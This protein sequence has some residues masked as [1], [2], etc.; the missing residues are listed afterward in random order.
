MIYLMN[1]ETNKF[2]GQFSSMKAVEQ[3]FTMYGITD[4]NKYIYL[5]KVEA[6]AYI[7]RI[8]Y[9]D[10]VVIYNN[11]NFWTTSALNVY[12][13]FDNHIVTDW[14]GNAITASYFYKEYME[15]A[16]RIQSISD[17]ADEVAYNIRIGSEFISLFREEC[18]TSD[19]G[20]QSGLSIATSLSNVIPLVQTGSFKEAAAVL[21]TVPRNDFLTDD[22][23]NKYMYMLLSADVISY[24]T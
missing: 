8:C 3:Y 14:R 2:C 4:T 18:I 16:G 6:M 11:K 19:I 23:L 22:L 17:S 1:I 20:D 5:Q 21:T 9:V 7:S 24:L 10:D 12:N 15:N 13:D